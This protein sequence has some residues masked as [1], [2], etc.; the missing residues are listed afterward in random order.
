MTEAYNP[1][2]AERVDALRSFI[3]AQVSATETAERIG[4]SREAAIS[5]A[6]RLGLRFH[7]PVQVAPK[8]NPKTA[9]LRTSEPMPAGRGVPLLQLRPFQ[10]RFIC[11]DV[12]G[13]RTLFCGEATVSAVSSWCPTHLKV[14]SAPEDPRTVRAR[15]RLAD[16]A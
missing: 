12:D 6:R 8:V 13:P 16:V 14:V 7:S 15:E 5:K 11:G 2:P 3:K 4:C 9:P 1:W 10:C